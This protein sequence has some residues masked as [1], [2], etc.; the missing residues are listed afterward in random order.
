MGETKFFK[1]VKNANATAT[2]NHPTDTQPQQD[3]ITRL[4]RVFSVCLK[5]AEKSQSLELSLLEAKAKVL[6]ADFVR[7]QI[8]AEY[9]AQQASA[10]RGAEAFNAFCNSRLG[11]KFATVAEAWVE[12][13]DRRGAAF[14]KASQDRY[15][16][17]ESRQDRIDELHQLIEITKLEQLLEKAKAGEDVRIAN[18]ISDEVIED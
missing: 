1:A 17:R 11:Q 15:L 12:R 2:S 14:E 9:A 3:K 18:H 10:E 16:A 8:Q 5:A 13:I 7:D 6:G 4:D